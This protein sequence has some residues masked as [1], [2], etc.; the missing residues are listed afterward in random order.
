MFILESLLAIG[1]TAVR[2][3]IRLL[4][5]GVH[6]AVGTPGRRKITQF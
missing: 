6:L 3:D 2:E 4:T 1:G 5:G